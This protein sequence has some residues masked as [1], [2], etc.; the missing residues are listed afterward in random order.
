MNSPKYRRAYLGWLNA[1][2]MK[3]N[4]KACQVT[5]KMKAVYSCEAYTPYHLSFAVERAS[6]IIERTHVCCLVANEGRFSSVPKLW[7]V[8]DPSHA[9]MK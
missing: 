1:L 6:Q 2:A 3:T 4:I 5:N 7:Y 8:K 9:L